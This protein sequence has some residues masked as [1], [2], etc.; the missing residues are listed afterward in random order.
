LQYA[1]LKKSL[2]MNYKIFFIFFLISL[3]SCIENPIKTSSKIDLKKENFSNKGFAL[4]YSENLILDKSVNKKINDR[5][6]L[7]FQKNLKKNTNVKITNLINNRSIL[8]KVGPSADYPFFYNS[9]ISKRI[10]IELDLFM[11]NPYVEI[12]ELAYNSSFVAKVSKTFDE[13]KNVASKA[14]VDE[15]KVS[16][17][18]KEKITIIEKTNKNFNYII[19]IADLY[20]RDSA[21]DLTTRIK[22]ETTIEKV[23]VNNLSK[24]QYRVFLGPFHNINLLQKAFNDIKILK[25]ENIEII[26]ND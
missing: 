20:F 25:F 5:D 1:H 19:K 12:K 26:Y 11:D 16:S 2:K 8:A 24:S 21:N 3:N 15:I 17:L 13:E 23:F 7:I 22:K 18:S 14:P 6:L 4:I 10:S 9:V